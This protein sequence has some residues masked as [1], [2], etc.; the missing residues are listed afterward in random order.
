MRVEPSRAR[1]QAERERV[2]PV[3]V[4]SAGEKREGESEIPYSV[5]T[6]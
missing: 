5:V 1:A 4:R 6:P 3:A 2:D